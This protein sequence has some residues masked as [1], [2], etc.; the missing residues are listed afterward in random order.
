MQNIIETYLESVEQLED[1]KEAF[2]EAQRRHQEITEV[3]KKAFY[4]LDTKTKE[5]G[6]AEGILHEGLHVYEVNHVKINMDV[7]EG[8]IETISPYS[9]VKITL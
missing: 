4:E 7:N 8:E 9:F 6:K 1:A 3:L 5:A 2:I